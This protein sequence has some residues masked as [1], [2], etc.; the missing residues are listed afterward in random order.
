MGTS[1][2]ALSH[3][4][5][6]CHFTCF[7][8]DSYAQEN[9]IH[10]K[11]TDGEIHLELPFPQMSVSLCPCHPHP[12]PPN[13]R[14]PSGG[15]GIFLCQ[16]LSFCLCL[17]VFCP[18]LFYLLFLPSLLTALRGKI[19]STY[20]L[21]K[22]LRSVCLLKWQSGPFGFVWLLFR[23]SLWMLIAVFVCFLPVVMLGV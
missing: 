22:D 12:S 19:D 10:L 1:E 21:W 14:P 8:M 2:S 7:K 4:L 13:P 3:L 23:S 11:I 15:A 9:L 20:F 6:Q 5:F 18:S 16:S 17:F